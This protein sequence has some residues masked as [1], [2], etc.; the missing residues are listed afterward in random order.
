M[1]SKAEMLARVWQ[2]EGKQG[3]LEVVLTTDV[4]APVVLHWGVR[5]QGKG[6]WVQPSDKLWPQGSSKATETAIDTPFQACLLPALHWLLC[7]RGL[8]SLHAWALA[9]FCAVVAH[10]CEVLYISLEGCSLTL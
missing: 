7:T 5:Q 6:E 4:A 1:G 8:C 3:P 10:G 2:R 9:L